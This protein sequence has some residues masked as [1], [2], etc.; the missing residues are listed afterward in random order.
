MC[1]HPVCHPASCGSGCWEILQQTH[2]QWSQAECQMGEV[3]AGGRSLED[4]ATRF[5]S[6]CSLEEQDWILSWSRYWVRKYLGSCYGLF[7]F[8][9]R[10]LGWRWHKLHK[11][12]KGFPGWRLWMSFC[13]FASNPAIVNTVY[14]LCISCLWYSVNFS[15][16][17]WS[18]SSRLDTVKLLWC[19][20]LLILPFLFLVLKRLSGF[21]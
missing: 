17:A 5:F 19:E 16:L 10:D 1:F 7:F 13:S 12:C 21:F 18:N 9:Q 14:T 4:A 20:Y 2:C 6:L 15:S 8:Q 3:S 11:L